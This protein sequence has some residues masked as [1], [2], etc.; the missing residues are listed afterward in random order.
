MIIGLTDIVRRN[1][2]KGMICA[3]VSTDFQKAFDSIPRGL[4]L[5]KLS[6]FFGISSHWLKSYLSNREQFVSV[7]MSNSKFLKTLAGVPA[8]S[9]I[10]PKLFILFLNDMGKGLKNGNLTCFADDSYVYFFGYAKNLQSLKDNVNNDM[11]YVVKYVKDSGMSMHKKKTNLLLIGSN[12]NINLSHGFHIVVND[13]MVHPSDQL[14]CVGIILDSKLNF[15]FHINYIAKRAYYR[16]RCLYCVRQYFSTS[17]LTT[18]GVAIV[19]SILSYMSCVWSATCAKYLYIAENVIRCLAR[20]VLKLRKFDPVARA[21]KCDLKWLF[22]QVLGEFKTLCIM[23]KLI[24]HDQVPFFKGYFSR[25]NS[26][27]DHGTRL[28]DNF[29]SMIKPK[30]EFVKKSFQYRGI[31]LWNAL[32]DHLKSEQSYANFK[33]KLKALM[34][35]KKL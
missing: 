13:V 34:L 14:K 29:R 5:Q 22:P 23:Y 17:S 1:I 16:I 28:S 9:V 33:N 19:L 32:P 26:I 27:H 3:V 15:E 11:S 2:D 35:Q 6:K 10:G 25:A 4:L 21:I 31:V 8:G 20:L 30:T 12:N 7:S 24:K 18:I